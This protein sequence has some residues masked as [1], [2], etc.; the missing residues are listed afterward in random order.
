MMKIQVEKPYTLD[1]HNDCV[2]SLESGPSSNI[3][4]SAA[5]D[6]MVA[7]WDLKNPEHG[8]LIAR[9]KN[10][11]YAL[12]YRPKEN[13][14][15]AGQNFEGIHFF[16]ISD[17]KDVG[18]VKISGAQIFDIKSHEN[19]ILIGTSEGVL[20]VLDFETR[21]FIKKIKLSDKSVRTIAIN[22][23][24]GDLAVGLSDNTIRIL[25]LETFKPKYLIHAHK[26]SVFTLLYDSKTDLL[27]SGSRDAHLKI[28]SSKDKYKLHESVVAHMYAINSISINSSNDLLVTCSMDKSIKVWD[29]DSFKLLK[30]IDKSRHAG[31]ATSV[32]KV[33]WTDHQDQIVSCSDDRKISVWELKFN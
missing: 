12:N 28:W 25:D 6:G 3:F 22:K 9:M 19:R 33:L 23:K 8:Q 30:V 2:Y 18:S 14:L 32:N 1:G 11:V 20:Y 5:G 29:L 10:S 24:L 27:I 15:L 16:D 13:I 17:R 7:A 26:L 4:Y 21:A 31:H